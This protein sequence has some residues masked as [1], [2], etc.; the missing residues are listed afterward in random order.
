MPV[1][2]SETASTSNGAR[3]QSA[4]KRTKRVQKKDKVYCSCKGRDDGRPMI[5]CD[6]CN[7][8]YAGHNCEP[9]PV[10]HIL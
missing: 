3:K 1:N 9:E 6:F 2:T 8:W 7:D 4:R 10:L 5:K